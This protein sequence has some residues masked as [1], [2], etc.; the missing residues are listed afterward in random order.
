[1]RVAIVE[2]RAVSPDVLPC[3]RNVVQVSDGDRGRGGI[4]L[5]ESRVSSVV[6]ELVRPGKE[7]LRGVKQP[8]ATQGIGHGR[9]G[10]DA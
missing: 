2:G 3:S 6:P 8:Y 10:T 7:G 4:F 9:P 1:M 5:E